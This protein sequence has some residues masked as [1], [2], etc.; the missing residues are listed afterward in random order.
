[1]R[2]RSS[3]LV[4]V[5]LTASPAAAQGTLDLASEAD[6]QFELGVAAQRGGDCRAALGH[7]LASQR[8]APNPNVAFNV[9][10]C[11]EQIERFA[12]AFRYYSDYL[13]TPELPAAERRPAE[14]ALRRIRRRVALLRIETDPPGATLYLDRRELGARGVSPRTLAVE[15]GRHR[16]FAD[17]EGHEPAQSDE[18]AVAVGEEQAVTLRLPAIFGEVRVLGRPEG[19]TVHVDEPDAPPAGT[20]GSAVPVPPGRRV[21]YVSAPGHQTRRYEVEVSPRDST[22][23]EVD[24]PREAGTLVTDTNERGALVEIDGEAAGFTPL[25]VSDVPA[26]RHVVR[27]TRD[28][29]RA[30]EEEVDI[31]PRQST[32][33]EARLRSEQEVL[34]ASRQAESADDAPASVSLVSQE[35]LRAFGYQTVWDAVAGQR[36]VY[37]SNDR[38]YASLGVRGFS[39]PQD[40]G[41]RVLSLTDGH[42]M[43]DDLLGSSY[44]G[45]DARSDLMDVER[46]EVVRGPGSAL[47]GADAFGGVINIITK[48]P[49]EGGGGITGA[50]GSQATTHGSLW[51][52]GRDGD[53]AWRVA[54]GYDYQPRWSREVPNGRADLVTGV[55]D[56]VESG[57]TTRI[58]ARATRKIGKIGTL[59]VGGGLSQGALEVLGVGLLNDIVL[60]RFASTD[61]TTYFEGGGFLARVFWNRLRADNTLNAVY[62][63]QS[64]QPGRAEQNVVDAEVVYRAQ[65]ELSASL[66]N[67]FRIGGAYRYKDVSWTFLDRRR[68]E[69]HFGL[70]IHDELRVAKPFAIV[71]DYRIDWVPYL[72]RF[73]Q[74][75]RGAVLVHPTKQSTIRASVATAFRKPTFLESYLRL[76]VQLP[77]TGTAQLSESV[78]TE[79]P[80]FRVDAERILSAELGYLNQESDFFVLDTA[81]YYNRVSNLIQLAQPRALT[82]GDFA[83][84]VGRLDPATGLFPV[85]LGGF[86]NQCQAYDVVGGEAGVRTFPLKG[87]DVYGNYSLN[88]IKQDNN[89]CTS[90]EVARLVADQRTSMHK[91]NAGV[92]LRTAPGFDGSIDFHFVSSQVWGEQVTNV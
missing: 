91:V 35:E 50:Y 87:L 33:V 19:A 1:M 3:L 43:N 5:L 28:G 39:Q 79:D 67:D 21:L 47:Y 64:L 61:L 70:F 14:E 32:R 85:A 55:G 72:Q 68:V 42:V 41:N 27:I 77:V 15:P 8:L 62:V 66:S 53:V 88:L 6:V 24:L 57:R 17:R 30:F 78:R 54:A 31:R 76:P 63:G 2:T 74:S 80:D 40:Y 7:Y 59:G 36:G 52:T 18:V 38:T 49:G 84:G 48:K 9:A 20:V 60:P 10:V 56:Q 92:Q 71:A 29:F 86:S 73:Q 83:A 13:E 82:V 44:V 89:S 46:I 65:T 23:L 16:V 58:D 90:E 25:V 51:A 26:G 22:R 81:A 45:F 34:A 12:E 4:A 75:P 11:F 37:Q 69:N